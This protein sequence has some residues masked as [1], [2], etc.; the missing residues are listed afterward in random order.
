MGFIQRNELCKITFILIYNQYEII[1]LAK[2][3]TK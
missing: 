3:K 1:Y 2:I